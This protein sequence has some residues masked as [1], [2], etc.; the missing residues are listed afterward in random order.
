MNPGLG[1]AAPA[2]TG[3]CYSDGLAGVNGTNDGNP[4]TSLQLK[5]RALNKEQQRLP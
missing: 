2:W 5:V 1:A 3:K 4:E